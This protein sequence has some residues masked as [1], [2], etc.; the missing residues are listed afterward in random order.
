MNRLRLSVKAIPLAMLLLGPVIAYVE[1]ILDFALRFVSSYPLTR[2]AAQ[3][4]VIGAVVGLISGIVCGVTACRP[5][6]S[7][8]WTAAIVVLLWTA[9]CA[10]M[11]AHQT[12]SASFHLQDLGIGV[13]KG[14]AAAATAYLT[15]RLTTKWE[16][17]DT[18]RPRPKS[19]GSDINPH[20]QRFRV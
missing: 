1:A 12:V 14:A 19:T 2:Y 7:A 18:S 15:A 6:A 8:I 9:F 10:V 17:W 5:K 20:A 3:T 11:E 13:I 4:L 16:A